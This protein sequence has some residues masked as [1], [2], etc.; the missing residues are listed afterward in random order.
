MKTKNLH[1]SIRWIAGGGTMSKPMYCPM[2]FVRSNNELNTECN[3]DCAWAK[4]D[5]ENYWCGHVRWEIQ[6]NNNTR[7]LKDDKE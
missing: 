4:N 2:S 7:P 1:A 5:G 3:P 6:A